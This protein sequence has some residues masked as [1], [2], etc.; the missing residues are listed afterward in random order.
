MKKTYLIKLV[1]TAMFAA[2]ACVF[3]IAIQI[4]SPMGGYINTG[5]GIVL[6]AG[7]L[8]GGGYGFLAA[9]VGSML[10][11]LFTGYAHYAIGTF[12]IKG[13]TALLAAWFFNSCFKLLH[14]KMVSRILS[15]LLSELFMVVGYFFYTGLFLGK[16]VAAAVSIPGNLVQGFAGIVIGILITQ[17]LLRNKTIC[18]L[19]NL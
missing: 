12:L 10:A 19:L 18:S 15:G 16:G 14:S 7:W 5:D 2:L 17:F 9:G 6:T 13:I 1:S 8:L 11:D 3:T 4:P